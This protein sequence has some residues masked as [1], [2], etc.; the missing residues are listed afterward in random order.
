M[1]RKLGQCDVE[2]D[3]LKNELEYLRSESKSGIVKRE[4]EKIAALKNEQAKVQEKLDKKQETLANLEAGLEKLHD[5]VKVKKEEVEKAEAAA[6]PPSVYQ[7]DR[8]VIENFLEQNKRYKKDVADLLDWRAKVN[9]KTLRSDDG[10]LGKEASDYKLRL[11][12]NDEQQSTRMPAKDRKAGTKD[13]PKPGSPPRSGGGGQ[14]K[15]Y[16]ASN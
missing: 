3:R 14:K 8:Q 12:W 15:K 9:A 7:S 1:Q 16:G 13:K 11:G 4:K 2:L 5:E 10:P 6:R